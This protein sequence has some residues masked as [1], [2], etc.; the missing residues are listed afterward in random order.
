[1]KD[2][3]LLAAV[4]ERDDLSD[5]ARAAFEDMQHKLDRWPLTKKQRQWIEAA[6]RGE[7]FE[8]EPEYEN[9]VSSGRVP[10]GREVPTPA[11]LQNLPKK[12]PP[13]RTES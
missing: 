3:A 9:L 10:R 7:K 12:P 5:A 4:L 6:L 13:R 8:P 2:L 11:I 1:M